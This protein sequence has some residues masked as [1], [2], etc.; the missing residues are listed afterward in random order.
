VRR[1]ATLAIALL[2]LVAPF[3]PL[4]L[5]AQAAEDDYPVP[6][7]FLPSAV[8][9]G[10]SQTLPGAN[11]WSCAPTRQHPRPVV[12]VHGTFANRNENWQTYAPLL[13][14]AGYCV[15]A[16]NYGANAAYPGSD[17]VGGLLPM[18]DGAAQ[19]KKFV[20]RV[21]RATVAKK[22]DLIGHSQGTLMP[23]YYVKFL[24]GASSVDHYISLAPLWH[25]TN[26]AQ[27][28]KA[29]AAL[30][31]REDATPFCQACG[32]FPPGSEFIKKMRAGGVEAHGV[33]Y[34]NIVTVYDELVVPYWSGIEP[35]MRNIVLQN[36]CPQDGSE[37]G[38]LAA[39]PNAAR[40]VLN[41]LDPATARPVRCRA[42]TGLGTVPGT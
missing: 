14:N 12:L 25:G 38:Q 18:E 2:A 7:D 31:G 13:A 8:Q 19:L 4:T 42:V 3:A 34:T 16:L 1:V 28:A 29:F 32:Q 9:G 11:D 21:R 6:Y 22:V 10:I 20:N 37:H 41:T 36:V 5:S 40:I 39:S 24:G 35:G 15:F 26:V 23:N 30:Y 27:P 33:R 17:Y